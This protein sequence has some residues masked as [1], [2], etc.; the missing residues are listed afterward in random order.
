MLFLFVTIFCNF[1]TCYNFTLYFIFPYSFIAIIFTI[2]YI[3]FNYIML[4]LILLLY[5]ISFSFPFFARPT[6]FYCSIITIII[7]YITI[8]LVMSF[9]FILLAR[10]P[11]FY[12]KNSLEKSQAINSYIYIFKCPIT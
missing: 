11:K 12:K 6:D 9:S 7:L 3:L 8:V 1:P 4:Y 5:D 2:C 10:C